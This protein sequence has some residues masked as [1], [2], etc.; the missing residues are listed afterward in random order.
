MV[1]GGYRELL[2]CPAQPEL[3]SRVT[4]CATGLA[5]HTARPRPL[6][7]ARAPTP[8]STL[9]HTR[10]P[11]HPCHPAGARPGLSL[12]GRTPS[13]P[14]GQPMALRRAA[15]SHSP[16]LTPTAKSS[17][18]PINI[19]IPVAG[20]SDV[21]LMISF[22]ILLQLWFHVFPSPPL[23]SGFRGTRVHFCG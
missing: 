19:L 15:S 3:L 10:P 14:C 12:P 23:V 6:T 8:V 11:P 4:R 13:M 7:P 9:A 20:W 5:A 21:E 22:S 17:Q 16:A 18:R 2:M 1:A